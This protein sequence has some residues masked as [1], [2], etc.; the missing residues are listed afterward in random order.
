[1]TLATRLTATIDHVNAMLAQNWLLP[2]QVESVGIIGEGRI[3]EVFVRFESGALLSSFVSCA[4]LS[5][6]TICDAVQRVYL[7]HYLEIPLPTEAGE[8]LEVIAYA[9]GANPAKTILH[10]DQTHSGPGT[11]Q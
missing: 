4:A 3:A 1:M 10:R 6:L 8:G 5:P 11:A 9:T 7:L 2:C